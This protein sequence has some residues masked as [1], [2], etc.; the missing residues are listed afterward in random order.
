M[1]LLLN[2]PLLICKGGIPGMKPTVTSPDN[3]Q[4]EQ[5]WLLRSLAHMHNC[6]KVNWK[7]ARFCFLVT[8]IIFWGQD[9]QKCWWELSL[10]RCL[11]ENLHLVCCALEA[12]CFRTEAPLLT[13]ALMNWETLLAQGREKEQACGVGVLQNLSSNLF[14]KVFQH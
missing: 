14:S 3:F 7:W 1:F 6:I 12:R 2:H 11:I 13:Q 10:I 4:G 9:S 5:F 8:M